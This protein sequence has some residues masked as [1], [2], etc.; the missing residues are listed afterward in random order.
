MMSTRSVRSS[1]TDESAMEAIITKVL[2]NS[3]SK[4]EDKLDKLTQ[5]FEALDATL[6]NAVT[7]L[8]RLEEKEK[9]NAMKIIIINQTLDNLNQ[10]AR[11]N[12]LRFVGV[13]EEAS[14]NVISKVLTLINDQ[15]KIKC[16]LVEVNRIFRVGKIEDEQKPRSI[17]VEFVTNL[18]RSEV[19]KSRNK[20]K[21]TGIFLNE[22]LTQVRFKLLLAAKKK[23]GVKSAWSMNG[24]I[25]VNTGNGVRTIQN[26]NELLN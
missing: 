13:K 6:N 7:K 2:T 14:E 25:Y 24:K 8:N 23:Y 11:M 5:K 17:I 12:S 1:V 21:N 9:N 20:L 10:T 26:E 22:D 19:Y 3:L 15:M 4:I 16:S 18:K